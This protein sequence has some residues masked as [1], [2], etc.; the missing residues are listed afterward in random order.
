MAHTIQLSFKLSRGGERTPRKESPSLPEYNV[1]LL[2]QSLTSIRIQIPELNQPHLV[3]ILDSG[4]DISLIN[5]E[6]LNEIPYVSTSQ[7][8]VIVYGITDKPIFLSKQIMVNLQIGDQNFRVNLFPTKTK[9]FQV[10][11]GRN[12]LRQY[13]ITLDFKKEHLVMETGEVISFLPNRPNLLKS[14]PLFDQSVI[15]EERNDEIKIKAQ[16]DS[17]IVLYPMASCNVELT[18]SKLDDGIYLV[19]VNLYLFIRYHIVVEEVESNMNS[20]F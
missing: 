8:D 6:L 19:L 10:L 18:H 7:S 16:L 3:A 20:K 13:A 17:S 5:E 14:H 9:I 15:A 2:Q 1:N 12:F 11:L 4:S